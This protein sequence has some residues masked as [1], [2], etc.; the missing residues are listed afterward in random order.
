MQVV[1]DSKYLQIK[2]I[3]RTKSTRKQW[4]GKL[5]KNLK[6][7]HSLTDFFKVKKI[8]SVRRRSTYTKD[9]IHSLN[10]IEQ[11]PPTE[12]WYV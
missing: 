7:R 9:D 1:L 12:K 6:H 11:Q 3:T 5:E 4:K 8:I 10:L 2:R